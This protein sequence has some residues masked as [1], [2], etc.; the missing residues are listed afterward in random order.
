VPQ[1]L[2]QAED[3]AAVEE[4]VL[5]EGMPEGMRRASRAGDAGPPAVA[6]Q[7]L[8]DAVPGQGLAFFIE[9]EPGCV[10]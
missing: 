3:I 5:G 2:L 10:H 8:L 1:Y 6:A 9:Q 7:H 4:I